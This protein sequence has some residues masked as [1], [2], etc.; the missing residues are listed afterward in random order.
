[1]NGVPLS[2]INP[3]PTSNASEVSISGPITLNSSTPL[4]VTIVGSLRPYW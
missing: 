1:M 2:T 4:P 3:L